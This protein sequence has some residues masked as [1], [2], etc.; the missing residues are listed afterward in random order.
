MSARKRLEASTAALTA[1]AAVLLSGWA[2]AQPAVTSGASFGNGTV[3]AQAGTSFVPSIGAV[4]V[5]TDNLDLAPPGR[6]KSGELGV[7]EPGLAFTHDSSRE[8]AEIDYTLHALFF[9][10]G[11]HDFLHS[12]YLL[13]VTQIIPEWF[14]VALVG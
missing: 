14:E 6:E 1:A 7:V 12:G 13:S 8:H 5:W 11:H 3:P 2:D 9:S 10:G 4:A